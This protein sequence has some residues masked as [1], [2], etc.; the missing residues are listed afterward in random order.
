MHEEINKDI[1]I[2]NYK[3]IEDNDLIDDLQ[4]NIVKTSHDVSDSNGYLL[5]IMV[6]QLFI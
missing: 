3:Y 6:K 4:V 5:P 2:D 1:K